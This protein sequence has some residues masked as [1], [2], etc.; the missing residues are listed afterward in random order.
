[1]TW[2]SIQLLRILIKLR[3]ERSSVMGL[4]GPAPKF[5]VD[6]FPSAKRELSGGCL[7]KV[8]GI[9]STLAPLLDSF[10]RM[11][12]ACKVAWKVAVY[13]KSTIQSH[14]GRRSSSSIASF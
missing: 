14:R 9:L 4:S 8:Q 1:V 3:V 2:E 5:L 12:G 6:S 10:N 11:V 13:G 7:S